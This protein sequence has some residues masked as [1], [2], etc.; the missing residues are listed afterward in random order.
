MTQNNLQLGSYGEDIAANY[1]ASLG[2]KVIERNFRKRYGEIDIIAKESDT[3][4]F[5]EVKTRKTSAFGS[6]AEAI[7]PGKLRALIKSAHY[8]KLLHPQLPAAMRIDLLS[9]VL[10]ENNKVKSL[11]LI[12]NI[13]S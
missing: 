11:E 5:V 3:L 10:T 2:L 6:P 4:V 7:T 9:L 13:T 1:L 12:K 8:Y